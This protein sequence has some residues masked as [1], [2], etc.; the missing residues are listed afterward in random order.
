MMNDK[1]P[2]SGIKAQP[3]IDSRL[4]ILKRQYTANSDML[5]PSTSG[6]GWSEELKCVVADKIVFDEWVKS[7]PTAKRL[8]NKSFPYYNELAIVY[9]KDHATGD[10][11]MGFSETL[12][13]ITEKI[14]NGWNDDYDPFDTLDEMNANASMNSNIPSSQTARKA[15]T[16]SNSGD[17]L[18][19][20]FFKSVQEFST[21]QA[22]ASDSIRKLVD[23]FQHEVDGTARRMNLYEE[24]KKVDGLT[25]SQRLKIE[26]LLIS[27]QPHID[28]FFTLEEQF[29]LDFLLGMLE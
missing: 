18:V 19:E 11:A 23:C 14:N 20:L 17:P 25:N 5:G 10:G 15:K 7:H 26:K 21:M 4:K 8:L 2:N 27:N 16:K 9:G 24:I 3:H 12:D 28:Y 29:K 13:E 6:F 22:S 1:I